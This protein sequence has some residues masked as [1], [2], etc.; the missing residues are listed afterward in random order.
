VWTYQ[1]KEILDPPEGFYG[2]VYIITN[3]LSSR[4]YIGKKLLYFKKTKIVKGKK[5]DFYPPPTG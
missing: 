3:N 1:S 4:Q 2:F 5:K